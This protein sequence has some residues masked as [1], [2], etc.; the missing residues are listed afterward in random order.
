MRGVLTLIFFMACSA[1]W[2]HPA[3]ETLRDVDAHTRTL[4]NANTSTPLWGGVTSGNPSLLGKLT[5]TRACLTFFPRGVGTG[6]SQS[7]LINLAGSFLLALSNVGGAGFAY[8]GFFNRLSPSA[9]YS[10]YQ[11]TAAG[12]VS[13]FKGLF[14]LGGAA[15]LEGYEVRLT[16][17]SAATQI[18]SSPFFNFS[19]GLQVQ[20][21]PSLGFGFALIRFLERASSSASDAALV[22]PKLRLGASLDQKYWLAVLD[23]ELTPSSS[24]LTL[25]P[26]AEWRLL[27]GNFHLGAGLEF[28]FPAS[29]VELTPSLGLGAILGILELDYGFSYPVGL[30]GFGNHFFTVAVRIGK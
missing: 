3:F 15:M 21:T 19:G 30:G 23:L 1:L 8:N 13:F 24:L 9:A 10:E 5:N 12:G 16:D 2:L 27:G 7:I 18:Q 4:A 14:S 20:P 22:D 6:D 26:A 29:G 25:R 11:F 28:R 17:A